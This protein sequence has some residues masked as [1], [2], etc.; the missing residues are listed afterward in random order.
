MLGQLIAGAGPA[1]VTYD[2]TVAQLGFTDAALLDR[3]VDALAA[4]DGAELFAIV[5][6]VVETGTDPR[7]FA[8]DLLERLRDLIVLHQV[9]D[10]AKL[11]LLDVPD[12]TLDTLRRQGG[13]LGQGQLSRAAD[14]VSAGLSELKGTTAPRLQLEL[15]GARLLLPAGDDSESGVLARLDRVERRIAYAAA[16]DGAPDAATRPAAAEPPAAA[17]AEVDPARDE[18]REQAAGR[19]RCRRP[20]PRPGRHRRRP[21]RRPRRGC[22]RSPRPSPRPRHPRLHPGPH[23]RPPP[24]R[25]A[26]A[27]GRARTRP[28]TSTRSGPGGPRS[29]RCS[30]HTA[31]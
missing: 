9:P 1:G 6:Q 4:A 29:S 20:H 30:G 23:Q 27:P 12:A 19:A 10:A 21:D 7:R 8:T 28:P 2:D 25:H 18:V 24:R 13:A 22:R 16:Q 3:V 11:G 14:L 15:L 5:E 26:P 31:R 17:P